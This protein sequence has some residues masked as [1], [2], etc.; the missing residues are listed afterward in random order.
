MTEQE[1]CEFLDDYLHQMQGLKMC[2]NANERYINDFLLK[3]TDS[4]TKQESLQYVRALL[5]K[6]RAEMQQRAETV[7]TWLP[8]ISNDQHRAVFEDRYL[9]GYTWEQI[10]DRRCYGH[11]Q[12]FVIRKKCIAEIAQKS[13]CDIVPKCNKE[14]SK[15]ATI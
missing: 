4:I 15:A 5:A 14:T 2:I 6:D 9:N 3:M 11:S 8:L 10:E 13:V 7:R 1:L 12:L